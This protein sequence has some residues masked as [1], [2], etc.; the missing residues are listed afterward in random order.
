MTASSL[1]RITAPAM[2]IVSTAEMKDHLRV[3]N[4]V[5]DVYIDALTAAATS[6]I[7][8]VGLL[9]KAM[10]TQT[11][12]QW[13]GGSA[14]DVMLQMSPAIAL[15]AVDYYAP[16]TNVLTAAV[17]ADFNIMGLPTARFVRPKPDKAWPSTYDRPD[18]IRLTYTAGYG[19]PTDVP[20]GLRQAVKLLVGHWYANRESVS[21]GSLQDVPMAFDALLNAERVA[22]Y[23]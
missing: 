4:D 22:W 23:G 12:G 14:G 6:L 3:T 15:T 13:V 10:V 9:G 16:T 17:A 8:G 18:A 2:P 7:D 21:D 20:M 1:V 19:A 11:W 5:E